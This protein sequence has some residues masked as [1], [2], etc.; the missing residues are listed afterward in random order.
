MINNIGD[1][2]NV[3]EYLNKVKSSKRSSISGGSPALRLMGFGHRI[4]KTKDP[5]AILCRQLLLE[6]ISY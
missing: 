1:P 4:Y 5:R 2:K 6:V 3:A